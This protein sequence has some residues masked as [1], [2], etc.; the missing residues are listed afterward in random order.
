M[1]TCYAGGR[2]PERPRAV[3]WDGRWR[4]VAAVEA[5]WRTLDGIHFRVR[6]ADG[7]RLH[8]FY[9]ETGKV[10]EISEAERSPTLPTSSLG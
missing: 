8:L 6:L 7:R 10:W 5:Q 9:S 3:L 2:Y 4:P 1:V